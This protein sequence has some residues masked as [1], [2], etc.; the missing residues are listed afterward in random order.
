[1]DLVPMSTSTALNRWDEEVKL[2]E[3]ELAL[4]QRLAA[5]GERGDAAASAELEKVR[6]HLRALGCSTASD[7]LIVP[8]IPAEQ[9]P[10][11]A[12][13]R[14]APVRP[15]KG[16]PEPEPEPE[17]EPL[18]VVPLPSVLR[19]STAARPATTTSRTETLGMVANYFATQLDA[20]SVDV[21]GRGSVLGYDT[22]GDGVVDTLDVSGD[23]HL[24][25]TVSGDGKSIT[26]DGR[27]ARQQSLAAKAVPLAERVTSRA[28]ESFDVQAG[29]TAGTGMPAP[30]PRVA[31]LEARR[32]KLNELREKRKAS[33]ARR[34][35]RP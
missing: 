31:E 13:T 4:M 29:S 15:S 28:D 2:R 17:P 1:M 33:E 7:P 22:S 23:G 10:V 32:A 30:S 5:A 8:S 27:R 12:W 25:A 14:K 6:A 18:P 19:T 20:E 3:A 16:Q 11:V 21:P 24:D 34:Q 26:M 9:S 35:G